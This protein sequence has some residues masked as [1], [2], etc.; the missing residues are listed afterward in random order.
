ML[1]GV[2]PVTGVGI[3]AYAH[4]PSRPYATQR[5]P[6]CGSSPIMIRDVMGRAPTVALSAKFY[7]WVFKIEG[8]WRQ[9]DMNKLPSESCDRLKRQTSHTVVL[10]PREQ[11]ITPLVWAILCHPPNPDRA[12]V[13]YHRQDTENRIRSSGESL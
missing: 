7:I 4:H 5:R 10:Q 13:Y 11:A 12:D 1:H 6:A 8:A 9:L 3:V 2:G